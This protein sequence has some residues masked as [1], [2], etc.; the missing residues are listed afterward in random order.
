MPTDMHA[1]WMPR[2]LAE[3]LSERTDPPMGRTSNGGAPRFDTAE[4]RLAEMDEHGFHRGVLSL[5]PA[6]GI[7][8]LPLEEA[9]PLCRVF[10]D[11]TAAACRAYPDR[12]SGF[13]LLPSADIGAMVD[14]FERAMAYPGM[15]G[16]VLP[17]DGFLSLRRAEKFRPIFQVGDARGALFLVHYGG[18]A[19]DP[20]A[21][22][23]DLSDN[24]GV[25]RGTLDMQARISSNMIT[26]CMTD[27]LDAYPN[28][29]VISH[30]LGGNIP[31][32][33]ERLDHR[34]MMD[35]PNEELPSKRI[36]AARMLVDC[37]SFGPRA[38]EMAVAVYGAE[39][40]VCGTDGTSFGMDWTRRAVAAARISESEKQAILDGNAAAALAHA[41]RPAATAAS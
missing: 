13:A 14:E 31:F 3:A 34:G 21:P 41:N 33:I 8:S 24:G 30:N 12:Y 19:D 22:R 38:I 37:N 28:V 15:V 32:E 7:D 40:I 10:N 39:K 35:R 25:R 23:P 4:S 5:S 18:L 16:A 11:A 6:G 29:T 1:H 2:A 20:Q 17:G 36:R 9:L 27:F 26:F